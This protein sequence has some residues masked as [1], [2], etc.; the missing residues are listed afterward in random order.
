MGSVL[1]LEPGDV[2]SGMRPAGDPVPSAL[3]QSAA[4]CPAR[5]SHLVPCPHCG[6]LNGRSAST[7]W[8]CEA[9]LP[10]MKLFEF[11]AAPGLAADPSEDPGPPPAAP[12]GSAPPEGRRPLALSHPATL[13][14]RRT[15]TIVAAV[16]CGGLVALGAWVYR[17]VSVPDFRAL[18]VTLPAPVAARAVGV[19]AEPQP[20]A[21][22]PAEP[23]RVQPTDVD[24]AE[25]ARLAAAVDE[26]VRGAAGP[27]A[28]RSATGALPKRDRTAA[29]R[30]R[31]AAPAS[32]T[33]TVAS[34]GLCAED[35][36][37]AAVPIPAPLP[38]QPEPEPAAQTSAPPGPCTAAVASLGLCAAAPDHAKE[39]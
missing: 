25:G 13:A 33:A 10:Q 8:G 32:C 2:A 5:D 39:E 36:A 7:C 20:V 11:T 29:A 38:R 19:V 37:A 22:V 12:L 14:R 31:P 17:Y 16:A 34:L 6:V 1:R 18:A 4:P 26:P 24:R 30:P 28:P 23:A 9:D 3:W 27:K 21:P 15:R 35:S